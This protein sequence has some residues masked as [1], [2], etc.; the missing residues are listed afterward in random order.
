VFGARHLV[1]TAA[2]AAPLAAA[3]AGIALGAGAFAFG[4]KPGPSGWSSGS[5]YNYTN[6]ED[7][8]SFA[9]SRCRSR[10]EAGDYCK[11]IATFNGKC[12]A[13]AVQEGGNGYG[14]T[15]AATLPEAQELAIGRCEKWG[16]SCSLRDSF[17]D[18]KTTATASPPAAAPS[19]P[20][21]A[22]SPNT[23]GGGSAACQKFPDLC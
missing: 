6:S 5:A 10:K 16:K 3:G 12:F 4:Q 13:I 23:G 9:M 15:T 20:P 21:P 19:A 18:T 17:C 8:Q 2:L 1:L 22:A 7:A 14:W 11:V